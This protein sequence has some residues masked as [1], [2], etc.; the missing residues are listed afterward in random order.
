MGVEKNMGKISKMDK[1]R[2]TTT[3]NSRYEIVGTK[4]IGDDVLLMMKKAIMVEEKS[5]MTSIMT[6]PMGYVNQMKLDAMK[7]AIVEQIIVTKEFNDK[8]KFKIGDII[9]ISVDV[10]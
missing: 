6:D 1:R 2:E 3:M 8:H 5:T 7:S 10:L 9:S 4:L